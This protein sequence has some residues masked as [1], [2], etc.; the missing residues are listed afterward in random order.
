MSREFGVDLEHHRSSI[1]TPSDLD[2][3]EVVVIM[4]R[5]NWVQVRR[6]RASQDKLVWLGALAPVGR[7]EIPDPYQLDDAEAHRLLT[8]LHACAKVLA[9]KVSARPDSL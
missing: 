7:V 9:E 8:R 1:I 6:T 5:K 3:A 2:W 4:D